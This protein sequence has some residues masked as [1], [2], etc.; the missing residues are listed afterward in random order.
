MYLPNH[1]STLVTLILVLIFPLRPFQFNPI[2]IPRQRPAKNLDPSPSSTPAQQTPHTLLTPLPHNPFHFVLPPPL[3]SLPP[4][5]L[6]SAIQV[7]S[8]N[9]PS[10][11]PLLFLY[12]FP[13]SNSL[14]RVYP[15]E[16]Y[17]VF[18]PADGGDVQLE[19]ACAFEVVGNNGNV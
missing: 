7:S 10:L 17:A 1:T 15:N 19:E 3:P 14:G 2:F 9:R 16:F 8:P 12:P 4:H 11:L 6:S 18:R 5:T 13:R